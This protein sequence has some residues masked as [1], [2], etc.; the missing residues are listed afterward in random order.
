MLRAHSVYA[1]ASMTGYRYREQPRGTLAPRSG[2]DVVLFDVGSDPERAATAIV[3]T[4]FYDRQTIRR[5]LLDL[6][7]IILDGATEER[8][9]RTALALTQAGCRAAAPRSGTWRRLSIEA[10][11]K[12]E[13]VDRAGRQV[14]QFLAGVPA[15]GPTERATLAAAA[16]EALGNA[17]YH[18][19]RESAAGTIRVEVVAKGDALEI[20]VED[21]GAGFEAARALERLDALPD[22]AGAAEQAAAARRAEG[23]RGGLGLLVIRRAADEVLFNERGNRITLRKRLSGR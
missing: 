12:R 9:L 18:G 10:Q 20:S 16:R 6:P 4:L 3:R 11:A 15:A 23:G 19:C 17:L 1:Q 13:H 14:E 2:H 7:A 8:A 22:G 5:L 21:S